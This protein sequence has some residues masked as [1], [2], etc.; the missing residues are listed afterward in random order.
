VF[1]V[2]WLITAL[3][4][5][6]LLRNLV[7]SRDPMMQVSYGLMLVPFLLRLLVLK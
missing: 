1:Y 5:G 6:L 4:A 3:L 7:T 2:Y